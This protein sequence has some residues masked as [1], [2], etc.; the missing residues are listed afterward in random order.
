MTVSIIHHAKIKFI[1]SHRNTNVSSVFYI[2]KINP[3]NIVI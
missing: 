3:E 1:F 2:I